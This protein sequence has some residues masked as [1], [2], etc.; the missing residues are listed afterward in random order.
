MPVEAES[1]FEI[2][3]EDFETWKLRVF[4]NEEAILEEDLDKMEELLQEDREFEEGVSN[5]WGTFHESNN[6][7]EKMLVHARGQQ[8]IIDRLWEELKECKKEV[9]S[10]RA[11]KERDMKEIEKWRKLAKGKSVA[12][13]KDELIA[14]FKDWLKGEGEIEEEEE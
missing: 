1:D 10:L 4:A 9:R 7:M 3:E 12:K 11:G 5:I 14:R 8:S 6:R 13:E 2:G